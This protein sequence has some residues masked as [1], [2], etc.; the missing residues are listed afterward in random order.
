MKSA[1]LPLGEITSRGKQIYE[2]KLRSLLEP[3]HVGKYLV[4]DVD[5][6][7][8]E[9]DEEHLAALDRVRARHPDGSFFSMRVGYEALARIGG[10]M[11]KI[12]Q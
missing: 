2:Q 6:G 1:A 10:R 12:K 9:M 4:I 7:D 11:M 3:E 8:Y 5:S